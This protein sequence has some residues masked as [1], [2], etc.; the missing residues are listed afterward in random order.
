MMNVKDVLYFVA[1]GFFIL[2]LVVPLLVKLFS[3]LIEKIR[4]KKGIERSCSEISKEEISSLVRAILCFIG[5]AVSVAASVIGV[6]VG[7]TKLYVLVIFSISLGSSLMSVIFNFYLISKRKVQDKAMQDER[8]KFESLIK[9]FGFE[10]KEVE[11][12]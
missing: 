8:M 7:T 11:K 5:N 12:F 2:C 6:H 1:M 3:M 10:E 9:A 4:S